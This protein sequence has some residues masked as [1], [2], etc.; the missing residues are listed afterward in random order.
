MIC[1][2]AIFSGLMTALVTGQTGPK[3]GIAQVG[4]D[5]IVIE[6]VT[7]ISPQRQAPLPHAS[8]LIRDGRIAL[9]GTGL[10][11]GPHAQPLRFE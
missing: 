2:A 9:I 8:I 6:D 3:P 10:I 1:A 4:D 7:L 11:A 5:G